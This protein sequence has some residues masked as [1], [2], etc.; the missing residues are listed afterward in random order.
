MPTDPTGITI[1]SY[2]FHFLIE[3]FETSTHLCAH[4][5]DLECYVVING[6]SL[7]VGGTVPLF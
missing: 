2:C 1:C 5:R 7:N 6:Q 4:S 3:E